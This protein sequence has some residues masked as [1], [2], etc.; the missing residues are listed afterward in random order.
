MLHN[1][2]PRNQ[3]M[4]GK[5]E[6][7]TFNLKCDPA[8]SFPIS[9]FEETRRTSSPITWTKPQLRTMPPL[10]HSHSGRNRWIADRSLASLRLSCRC[11]P[12]KLWQRPTLLPPSSEKAS[13][14]INTQRTQSEI[15]LLLLENEIYTMRLK[16]TVSKMIRSSLIPC[17][18]GRQMLTTE[19]GRESARYPLAIAVATT[20]NL[21]RVMMNRKTLDNL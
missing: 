21:H 3:N 4:R 15:F 9:A 7:K 12:N 11:A 17:A 14:A 8:S 19:N 5:Q 13:P 16:L 10:L 6:R 1:F 2:S 20:K 18:W